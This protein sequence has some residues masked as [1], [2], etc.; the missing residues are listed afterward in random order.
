MTDTDKPKYILDDLL[1]EIVEDEIADRDARRI[2]SQDDIKRLIVE[3]RKRRSKASKTK[4][5]S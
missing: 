1:A 5:S 3:S 4:A 2:I